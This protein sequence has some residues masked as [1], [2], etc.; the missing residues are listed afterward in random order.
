MNLNQ[1]RFAN[2][3]AATG[4]FTAAAAQC[5]VTQPTL[6]NGIGQLED[7]LGQR[8]F[9]RTTRKVGLTPFG[10]HILPY[11]AAVLS[12]Q[13]TLLLQT[14]TFLK[15]HKRLIRIGTSPLINANLL[16]LMLEPFRQQNPGVDV[17][18]REMNMTDLYRMLDEGL[19]DFVFGVADVHKGSW[20][21][22]HLYEEPLLFIPRGAIWP[23]RPRAQTVQLKDIAD[24]TFVMVPDACG[25]A[26]ATRAL[27]RSE[28]RTLHEY[29]GEAMSYQVLAQ[30]AKLGIGAAILPQSKLPSDGSPAFPVCGK[31]GQAEMLGFAA[32]WSRTGLQAPHLHD[33]AD[34]LCKVVPAIVGGLEP[35]ST[36]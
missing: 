16:G 6:S 15:P 21:S 27:F 13:A 9:V 8:L 10:A 22:T 5:C 11:I 20:I 14:Q 25:L 26:R 19:L 1:L 2:A 32:S 4:S 24:E 17:V 31:S 7:E 29:S 30:W 28:R 34:H 18:L 36:Q 33:F 3:V 12:A 35:G 23:N